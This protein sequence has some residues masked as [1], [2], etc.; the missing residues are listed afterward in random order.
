MKPIQIFFLL[1][2]I[3]L[4]CSKKPHSNG[5]ISPVNLLCENSLNPSGID[6]LQPSLSWQSVSEQRGEEQT[7]YRVLVAATSEDLENDNGTL[8]DS[9]KIKS[10]HSLNIKYSGVPLKSGEECFWK[11][12]VWSKN[13]VESEWSETA[14]WS[15]GLLNEEDWKGRW[16]GLDRSFAGDDIEGEF[17]KLA[18]RYFRKEFEISKEVKS[19]TAYI[20]GLG[21]YELR[22]NGEK[23]GDM[24]LAPDATQY[25]KRIFY[26][27]FDVTSMIEIGQ[28]AVGIVLG[29]GRYFAMRNH[30]P[31]KMEHYGFPKLVM[32]INIEYGDGSNEVIISDENWRVTANGPITEN[33]EYD[34]EKYDARKELTGW[35][36]PGYIPI[37]WLN[38]ELVTAPPG[39]FSAPL[40]EPIRVTGHIRPVSVNEVSPGVFIYDLGQNMVGW[41]RLSVEG[42][43]GDRVVMR[44]AETLREDGTLYLDNI[45]SAKVTDIYTLKGG[46]PETWEPE[47]T[48]HGFRYVEIR[49]YP[50]KP[51]LNTIL[52]CVV[53]NDV[54]TNGTFE[55]ASD[56]LNQV[57]KNAVWGIR[58]N[59]RSM[60]TDC[61][62]RDERMGWL[63][64]RAT[65][66]RGESYM[67][68]N[69]NLYRK[70]LADMRDD[71]TGEGSIPD[72]TPA[73]WRLYNDN[74]TWDGTGIMVAEMLYDQFG[75]VD[76][77]HEHYPAMKKW[78]RYMQNRYMTGFLMP[79]DTYG[80]WCMPPEEMWMIHSSDPDRI[81]SG[82]L[83]G[84]AFYYH[85][86]RIMQRFANQLGFPEDEALFEALA[87]SMEVAYNKEYFV[88]SMNYY[89]NNTPTANLLSLGFGLVPEKHREAVFNHIIEKIETDGN[90][91]IMVGLIGIMYL[92]RVLTEY[93][94]PDIALR[95][96]TETEYPSWGYMAING[97]TTIWELWNGN[98]ADPSMNSGNHAML[99]GDLIIWIYENIGGIKPGEPGFKEILMKPIVTEELPSATASHNSPYGKIYS[100]WELDGNNNFTWDIEI[101]VNTTAKIYLPANGRSDVREGNRKITR[102]GGVKLLGCKDGLLSCEI[103]SGIY[104]FVSGNVSFPKNS[105]INS[106]TVKISPGDRSSG[107]NITVTMNCGDPEAVIRYTTDGTEP[108]EISEKYTGPVEISKTSLVQARSYKEPYKPGYVTRRLYDIYDPE[109]NGLN[110]DYFEGRWENIPDFQEM[111]PLNR[112]RINGFNPSEIK[113]TED[114]WGIRFHGFVEIPRDGLYQFSTISDDGS[115]LFVNDTMVVDNDGIHGPFT[116]KG[117]IE[118]KRGKYPFMLDFFEGNYGEMLRVEIEGPG[119]ILQSLPVSMLYFE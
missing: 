1:T 52:G 118:L 99:L 117:K 20:S 59:Y 17:R 95:F 102:A 5:G 60:P 88:E 43:R 106:A 2:L 81:T 10:C 58:G 111:K 65:G 85:D 23:I 25:N 11:V 26:N 6:L 71:Q 38:A 61:P 49:E 108:S 98:T 4:S 66:C 86:A 24:V 46:G 33:N 13:D 35:D 30:I 115:R 67:F 104:H 18:A 63:G 47:F 69:Y 56:L 36:K 41:V 21:L 74:V 32:Q 90:G 27:S 109:L 48:Y 77:V 78:M 3:L 44:F 19:A 92:Q 83:I 73:Y 28:N 75:G 39:K 34:G 7:A 42:K 105:N 113:E 94:R 54:Q 12:K 103:T 119:M 91:H 114:Y 70:W 107:E 37:N 15:M 80:D 84:T 79:R 72:V 40:I 100:S 112:G 87:D 57:Y 22:L 14:H 82:A 97:A 62:Q 45:R 53:N 76:A 8:W 101:P 29:N 93:G 55:C 96:A 31:M 116:S 16:I 110:F 89:S 64:D 9:K 68:N 51:D 50:G